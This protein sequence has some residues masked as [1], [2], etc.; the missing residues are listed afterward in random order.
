MNYNVM[1]TCVRLLILAV[2]K[3]MTYA[4]CVSVAFVI[5]RED[6][7]RSIVLPAVTYPAVHDL[8]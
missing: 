1:L 8:K 4:K 6:R 5:Q 7:M 3:H 2:D